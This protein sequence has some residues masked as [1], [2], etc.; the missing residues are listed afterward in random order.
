MPKRWYKRL[1]TKAKGLMTFQENIWQIICDSLN[2]AKKKAQKDGRLYFNIT[3]EVEP[4]S[5][6]Y[7]ID[8]RKVIIKGTP[9]MEQEEYEESQKM[10]DALQKNFK[11]DFDVDENMSKQFN[12]KML[13]PEKVKDAYSKGYGA[14]KNKNIS[15]KLLEMGILTY[16]EKID[17]YESRDSY[18]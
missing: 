1:A 4:E 14:V 3:K 5:M 6:H 10:Y 7:Q 11:K 18:F 16:I 8:W 12:T 17:D 2:K 15:D 13:N 9:E